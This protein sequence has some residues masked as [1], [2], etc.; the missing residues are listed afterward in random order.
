MLQTEIERLRELGE[1]KA[2][3]DVAFKLRRISSATIDTTSPPHAKF[4]TASKRRLKLSPPLGIPRGGLLLAIYL[5]FASSG[6]GAA[7]TS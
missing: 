6:W 3:G 4:Y 7:E 5:G 1:V 2:L